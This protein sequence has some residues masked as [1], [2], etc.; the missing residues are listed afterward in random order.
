MD[1]ASPTCE[2]KNSQIDKKRATCLIIYWF[3][4]SSKGILKKNP[5]IY[6]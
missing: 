3:P 1:K 4:V 5:L 6:R 2:W